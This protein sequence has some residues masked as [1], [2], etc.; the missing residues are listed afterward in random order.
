[1]PGFSVKRLRSSPANPISALHLPRPCTTPSPSGPLYNISL[2]WAQ[3]PQLLTAPSR[4]YRPY[5]HFPRTSAPANVCGSTISLHAPLIQH[6]ISTFRARQPTFQKAGIIPTKTTYP[7]PAQTNPSPSETPIP[8]RPTSKAHHAPIPPPPL[9]VIQ[10]IATRRG[11]SLPHLNFHPGLI[12]PQ[13]NR[14]I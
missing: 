4:P 6:S 7:P 12:R 9:L 10:A 1:M 14:E 8:A 5:C 2:L 13:L 11:V 3:P